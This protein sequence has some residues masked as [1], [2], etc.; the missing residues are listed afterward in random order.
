MINSTTVDAHLFRV[1]VFFLQILYLPILLKKHII[2]DNETG[3]E[4]F[5][6]QIC[7]R[8]C[9]QHEVKYLSG[10]M[11]H[12]ISLADLLPPVPTFI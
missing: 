1:V 10:S 9:Y 5:C 12:Q 11:S 7:E 8:A 4:H 2:S 3:V 6:P